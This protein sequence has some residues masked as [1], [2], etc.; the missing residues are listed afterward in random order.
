M[1]SSRQK[2]LQ[3]VVA[4]SLMMTAFSWGSVEAVPEGGIVRSGDADISKQN[5]TLVIDQHSQ[6]VALDWNTFDIAKGE[7]VRF[8]QQKSDIALNRVIGNK[9]SEIYGSLQ[10]DGTVLLLNPHGVL[11]GQGAQV[12]VG[13]L[14]ASTAQVDDSFM[15][16]FG[17]SVE[18]IS[19][20]LGEASDGK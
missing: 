18:A 6:R 4:L 7:T 17:D 15:T 9:A 20:K 19:L 11:F 8:I 13:S 1:K 3:Q 14:V 16:G 2:A 12:D 10:A 5:Q